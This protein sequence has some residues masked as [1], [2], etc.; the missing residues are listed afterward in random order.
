M[1]VLHVVS[2]SQRRGAEVFASDLV[3]QLARAGICQH[4]AVLWG[5]PSAGVAFQ[6]EVTALSSDGGRVHAGW[7]VRAATLRGVA[8]EWRPDVVHAH[9]GDA[10]KHAVLADPRARAPIIYR[11]IGLAG[12]WAK[13]GARRWLYTLLMRRAAKVVAVAEV[14]GRETVATFRVPTAR[15]VTLPNLVDADRLRP[16]TERGE[17][18]R[19]LGVPAAA[20]VALTVG[21]LSWEK[22]PLAQLQ[23][24][25]AV[26]EARPDAF[27]LIVGDGPMAGELH[28]EVE[29]RRLG[30]R[31]LLLGGRDDVADLLGAADVLVLAS[32]S[33]GMEG[34]PAVVIEAG[35]AGVPVVSFDVAGVSEVV[36]HGHTG[37][38]VPPGD[39]AALADGVRALFDHDALRRQL[40]RRAQDRCRQS[41]SFEGRLGAYLDLYAEVAAQAAR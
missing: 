2:T 7:A 41:F 25:A 19:R 29:R 38:L 11:N 13:R 3:R 17:V 24:A 20:R 10:L 8:R 31:V 5:P 28:L 21:S 12:P 32:R 40:G 15:V 18:R 35:L 23:V 30:G 1:R 37:L 4:V 9:G 6:A 14:V 16:A 26:L 34:M 39:R 22:D 36:E 33:G 27:F